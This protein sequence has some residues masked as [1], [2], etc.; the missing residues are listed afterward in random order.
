MPP[1]ADPFAGDVSWLWRPGDV[2][3][4][5]RSA[6]DGLGFHSVVE[7]LAGAKQAARDGE[8]AAREQARQRNAAYKAYLT[9]HPAVLKQSKG[10]TSTAA[11]LWDQAG[12][13]VQFPG[14][15]GVESWGAPDYVSRQFLA[16]YN[17]GYLMN[18]VV[19][20]T[21]N[22]L[23]QILGGIP[24]T[25]YKRSGQAK[26]AD[27][28][29]QDHPAYALLQNPS[30]EYGWPELIGQWLLSY[31]LDG[32]GYWFVVGPEQGGFGTPTYLQVMAP[33]YTMPIPAGTMQSVL[34]YDYLIPGQTQFLEPGVVCHTRRY[35]PL[36]PYRGLPPLMA[37]ARAI[38]VNNAAWCWNYMLTQHGA[39]PPVLFKPSNP[40]PK[41]WPSTAQ[42]ADVRKDLMQ[43]YSGAVNAG[44]GLVLP[45]SLDAQVIGLSPADMNWS[46]GIV[47]SSLAICNVLGVPGQTIGIP[48]SQ[49]YANY[50]EADRML[51]VSTALPLLEVCLGALS[52]HL[53]MRYNDP[54]LYL[55][56]QRNDIEALA[57]DS[58][59]EAD[60]LAKSTWMTVNEKREAQG[61]TP[62]PPEQGG[63]LVLVPTTAQSLDVLTEGMG[64]SLRTGVA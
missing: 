5:F 9:A 15:V 39:V 32:N 43:N 58:G 25:V 14:S 41:Y 45:G 7:E 53:A 6:L 24:V 57:K 3:N 63:S 20:A 49:K 40:D 37:C 38:D 23:M 29:V 30:P 54:T 8:G 21:V 12:E 17:E 64:E 56:Y 52:R 11:L 47:K 51:H 60:R 59:S 33:N 31:L 22:L 61:L 46:D 13:G 35:N 55:G 10:L 27:E 18:P 42:L 4:P 48:D 34:R 2:D 28:E 1:P 19:G 36:Y 50:Q 26:V 62:L 44:K 16:Y